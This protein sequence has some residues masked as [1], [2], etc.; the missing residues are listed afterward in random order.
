MKLKLIAAAVAGIVAAPAVFADSANVEIYGAVGQMVESVKAAGGS[1]AEK[2]SMIRVSDMSSRIGFKGTEDL[3]N[4]LKALWQIE[5]KAPVDTGDG[6][7]AGRNSFVGVQGGFGTVR[8]GTYDA[9]YKDIGGELDLLE[10][11]NASPYGQTWGR[12]DQR[13]KNTLHYTSPD[14]SGLTVRAAYI[15]GENKTGGAAGTDPNALSLSAVYTMGGLKI[16]GGYETRKDTQSSL[17]NGEIKFDPATPANN[18][19]DAKTNG[20][21][22]VASYTDA[23][24]IVG[25]G[26]EQ[27]TAKPASGTDLKQT[28][29][30]VGAGYNLSKELRLALN[31]TSIGK[32]D[33]IGAT[34]AD[35][36]SKQ[37]SL[38]ATYDLSKRTRLTA[39]Y[40]KLSNE[41]L[42]KRDLSG[43]KISGLSN[44]QDPVAIGLGI[45]HKF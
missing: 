35:Y 12:L 42:V 22:L 45:R 9:P 32:L 21:K 44:D 33:G 43:V 31:Y 17:T 18:V 5:S 6:T 14:I 20:L 36:K 19:K 7:L 37:V 30:M 27:I 38:G 40:T 25:G 1:A 2:P 13:A 4:G 10:Y 15:A 41:A 26:V 3:G 8:L 23:A 39:F 28:T 11:S 24:F 34:E 16:A 29:M